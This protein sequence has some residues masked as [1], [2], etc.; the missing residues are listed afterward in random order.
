M[1]TKNIL[2]ITEARKNIFK[3]SDAV[4]KSGVYY[5]L[6]QHG[7]AKAVLMSAEQFDSWQETIE[8]IRDFPNL[9][10]DIKEAE[11][12]LRFGKTISLEEALA[13]QGYVL[14]DKAKKSYVPSGIK[15]KSR[16]RTRKNSKPAKR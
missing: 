5:T 10:N 11:E 7:R 1:S 15:S 14:A 8:V 13:K 6:V 2:S 4:Q 16:Q 12:D 3:L 9:K